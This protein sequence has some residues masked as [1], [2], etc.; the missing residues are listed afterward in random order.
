MP[1]SKLTQFTK[2][3]HN[4]EKLLPPTNVKEASK[5]ILLL[6]K[7]LQEEFKSYWHEM[8]HT[9]FAKTSK[10]GNNKLRTYKLFKPHF[11][12][13]KY[14]ELCDPT[15]RRALSQLRLSA[16]KLK[17]ETGRY[18]SQNQYVPPAN[19]ICQNCDLS[20]TEDEKHFLL[21]CS[22]YSAERVKL[23]SLI[24]SNN[25]YFND[26]DDNQKFLWL[27]TNENLKNMKSISTFILEAIH[28]RQ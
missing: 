7:H 18:S 26:Y 14:L 1:H 8:V 27:M 12:K 16:H 24:S 5:N 23:F 9:D 22:R 20:T 2:N 25:N 15:L 13:E 21:H 6:R 28:L 10:T 19:R 3:I 17:I 11:G 4:L